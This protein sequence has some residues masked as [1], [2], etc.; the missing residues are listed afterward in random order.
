MKTEHIAN[1]RIVGDDYF[2]LIYSR[3]C[4]MTLKTHL[5]KFDPN[6]YWILKSSYTQRIVLY[7]DLLDFKY[8]GYIFFKKDLYN[9]DKIMEWVD[10]FKEKGGVQ[11]LSRPTP[12]F[13][14]NKIIVRK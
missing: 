13:N 6:E 7:K 11:Y 3:K 2:R 10:W 4:K 5:D 1:R 8:S 9:I 12:P 14:P